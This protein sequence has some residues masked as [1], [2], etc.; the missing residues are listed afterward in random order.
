MP[1][2]VTERTLSSASFSAADQAAELTRR[3]AMARAGAD[4]PPRFEDLML[5]GLGAI[6]DRVV[7][8]ASAGSDWEIRRLGCAAA[9]G[10][11]G[12][13]RETR[14]SELAP[15]C[16]FALERAAKRAITDGEPRQREA[17]FARHGHAQRY[18][19]LALPLAN[20]WGSPLVAIHLAERGQ[21]YNLIDALF[22]ASD[23]GVMALAIVH[24]EAQRPA[25]F[26][27]VDVNAA[28]AKLLG[29]PAEGL[30]WR[31]LSEE[32]L[33][34]AAESLAERLRQLIVTGGARERFELTLRGEAAARIVGVN[35]TRMDDLF[36]ATLTDITEF[37]Q[38]EESYRLL[39]AANPMPMW[40][41]DARTQRL[42]AV[43]DAAIEHYG[44]SRDRFLAMSADELRLDDAE[45]EEAP[46]ETDV[47]AG[48]YER[49]RRADGEPIDAL[50]FA[51]AIA[52]AGQ[53]A[54]LTA[55]ADVTERRR[56]AA[57]AAYLAR[58]DALTGLSNRA[59][60]RARL[61]S[62]ID[63]GRAGG[64][65]LAICCLDLDLFKDVNDTY[66]HPTGDRLLRLVA[67]RLR[68]A[69]GERDFA[70]RIGG[71]EFA[72]VLDAAAAPDAIDATAAQIIDTLTQPY[73]IDGIEATIGASVG[74]ALFPAD[75]A[76]ADELIM[77]ADLALYQAKSE[78]GRRHRFFQQDL[79]RAALER[80]ELEADLRDALAERQL[81]VHYQ[82]LVDI[83][84][85]RVTG[86]E[87][88][89]RWRHPTRGLIAPN[90]FIPIAEANGLIVPIGE[91][92]LRTACAD[93]ANWPE[94]I[95]VA[96]NL[97]PVQFGAANLTQ[98]VVSA[99]AQSGL[100]ARRLELE[101][102]ESALLADTAATAATLR[103]LRRFGVRIALDDFG[104]GYSSLSHLRGFPFDKIKIDRSFVKDLAARR[105][106][107]AIVTAISSLAR[108]LGVA[109]TA[110]GV[111][112]A[113][114]LD[115]LR[116][117][118]CTQ[119]QGFLFSP[120]RPNADLAALLGR[121]NGGEMAAA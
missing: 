108:S 79:Q 84:G 5:D 102:T 38:R 9:A 57:E 92:V 99:L 90:D 85:R 55:V 96:V 60:F 94:E 62:A 115:F 42:L 76:S 48:Q 32:G 104:A 4:A 83:S 69:L 109:T 51:R 98:T 7:L 1:A 30:R 74:V 22:H 107:T 53:A 111:E 103:A 58:H 40:I 8:L 91:W 117:Q 54:E 11:G 3:W 44:Y 105:D 120:A 93:A 75:G 47:H 19:I 68:D 73:A 37:K 14:L 56:A 18:D 27:I 61:T 50:V 67:Q 16:G 43:N 116:A 23:D 45:A 66:G 114:Q 26:Q 6:D 106:C 35:L 34:S 101:I 121:I 15:D 41:V 119:A 12:G 78:G 112:T 95:A 46:D 87:A 21:G 97:S 65:R 81:E 33:G 31:R 89:L 17:F 52:Y 10:L 24:D 39:F 63:A 49:H 64:Q 100:A 86:F 110:E 88:L 82:P 71:D 20:R 25:D 13:G 2:L 29:A 118:G 70:A 80:R 113:E 28:A 36:C 77:N 59:D 72:V